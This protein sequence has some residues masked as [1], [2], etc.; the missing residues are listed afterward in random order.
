MDEICRLGL[1]ITMGSLTGALFF[2]WV[3]ARISFWKAEGVK[4]LEPGYVPPL[5]KWHR[6]FIRMALGKLFVFLYVGR[7]RIINK[8]YLKYCGRVIA[9]PNH[10]TE[11]DAVLLTFLMGMRN[12]R[13]FIAKTQAGGIR[14]PLIAFTGGITVEHETKRGPLRALQAA[15]RAMQEEPNTD[16]I[17]FPQGK[18]VKD[19]TLQRGEFFEGVIVLGEKSAEESMRTVAYLPIGIYYDRNPKNATLL[20]KLLRGIGFKNFRSFFG[21]VVSGA[22]VAVGKPMPADAQPEDKKAAMDNLFA[23]I[24]EMCGVAK[25][26]AEG[27]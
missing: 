23:Q 16:F 22:Y 13:Y 27:A 15:I 26:A 25:N 18:L 20:H 10:Q 5:P 4:V 8:R 14:A 17:I 11:R 24:V 9:S 7:L 2:L 3:G 1:L 19:N 6:R 12:A 21:D